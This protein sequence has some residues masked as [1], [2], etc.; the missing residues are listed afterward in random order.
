MEKQAQPQAPAPGQALADDFDLEKFQ[1]EF[2]ATA[3]ENKKKLNEVEG[4]MKELRTLMANLEQQKKEI[5]GI[6]SE[7]AKLS[8]DIKKEVKSQ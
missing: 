5:E 3:A 7:V 2:E 6:E 4:K 8:A 1:K